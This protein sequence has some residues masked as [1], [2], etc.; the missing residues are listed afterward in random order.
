MAHYRIDRMDLVEIVDEKITKREDLKSFSVKKHKKQIFNMFAGKDTSV[1]IRI[2]KRLIDAM[3]DKFGSSI[4]MKMVSETEAEFTQDVQ[5]SSAFIGWC[6]SFGDKLKV[7]S[8]SSVIDKIN[9]Q[10]KTLTEM[11]N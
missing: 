5:I 7:I 8:P 4:R 9:E 3:Y 11:Y 1:T 10:I 2:D 6:I